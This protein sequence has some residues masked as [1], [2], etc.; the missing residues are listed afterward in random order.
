MPSFSV[1]FT[2]T[3]ED[4]VGSLNP[5][6]GGSGW[7]DRLDPNLDRGPAAE[8]LFRKTLKTVGNFDFVVS[9]KIDKATTDR[10]HFLS[11]TA[12]RASEGPEGIPSDRIPC[13][14]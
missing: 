3:I 14:A 12:R 8:K 5:I 2:A 10:P 7:R 4:T 1:S 13:A 11:H 9:T 6:L